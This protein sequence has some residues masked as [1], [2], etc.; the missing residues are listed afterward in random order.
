MIHSEKALSF[1]RL[2]H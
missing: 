1:K 2:L